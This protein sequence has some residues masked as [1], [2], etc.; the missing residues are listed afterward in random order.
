M[1]WDDEGRSG[2]VYLALMELVDAGRRAEV[3]WRASP[4]FVTFADYAELDELRAEY[5]E[6][7]E[8]AVREVIVAHDEP[9]FVGERTQ[10]HFPAWS[11]ARFLALWAGEG[12]LAFYL[13]I[14]QPRRDE[15]I[16]LR[17]GVR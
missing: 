11:E 4:P 7:F 9:R 14:H 8:D 13:A 3:V 17:I 16:E 6:A 15:R 10:P 1:D 5:R 2:D 12:D